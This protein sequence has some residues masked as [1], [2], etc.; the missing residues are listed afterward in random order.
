MNPLKEP[1]P[2][3]H[4]GNELLRITTLILVIGFLFEYLIIPFERTP[5]EHLYSYPIICLFHVG[6]A[7]IVYF[8]YF[9]VVGQLVRDEDWQ[10]YKEIIAVF[11]L[12]LFIGIGEWAIRP[13]IYDSPSNHTWPI[14]WEEIWHAYLAGSIILLLVLTTNVKILKSRNFQR[15]KRLNIRSKPLNSDQIIE[16]KTQ[17]Q[18]ENFEI[19]P[20]EL[21]CACAAGNYVEIYTSEA[22]VMQ[23]SLKRLTLQ[24]LY[25]QL[26]DYEY[27]LK[28]HRAF[29]I[30]T[31]YIN[32]VKGNAQGYQLMVDH[33][34]FSVPVSRKH[35]KSFNEALSEA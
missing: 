33:I 7:A 1:Y 10:V 22:G 9:L 29:L 31:A 13:L 3:F 18:S 23:K 21:I 8:L 35:L 17:V 32:E 20:K 19:N 12:L 28:T 5:E 14:F 16:I 4:K 27:I 2:F 30:N 26:K 34:D 6:V 25:D 24:G 15:S 11:F